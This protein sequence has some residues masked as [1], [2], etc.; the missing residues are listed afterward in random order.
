MTGISEY[1]Q[2]YGFMA[3]KELGSKVARIGFKNAYLSP[4]PHPLNPLKTSG[5]SSQ[6]YFKFVPKEIVY[7]KLQQCFVKW[8]A[9]DMT[10][11]T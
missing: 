8:V 6:I 7:G 5:L 4:P 11:A 3:K 9:R 10:V 1:C 2:I